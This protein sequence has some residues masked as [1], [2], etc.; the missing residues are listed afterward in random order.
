ME[1]HF[2]IFVQ[3]I[4]SAAGKAFTELFANNEKFY[5]CTL[6]TTGEGLAPLISAWS[7][8]ALERESS[9]YKDIENYSEIIKWSYADSPYFAYKYENFEHIFSSRPLMYTLNAEE[10]E[11]EISF[12]LKIMETA[13]KRLDEDG[14]FSAGQN[15]E[16]ICLEAGTMPPDKR[17][18]EITRRLNNPDS[19]IMKQYMAEAAE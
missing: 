1:N 9:L 4:V 10:W 14:I 3:E 18:T 15:R 11:D 16:N 7:E 17:T 12:R 2:E 19:S 13:M 6:L 5:Y 8:E